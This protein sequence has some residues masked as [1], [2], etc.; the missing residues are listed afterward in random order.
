MWPS[1]AAFTTMKAVVAGIG[2]D[3]V[4]IARFDALL[5]RH[6]GRF[7][8][9]AFAPAEIATFLAKTDRLRDCTDAPTQRATC[10]R[11]EW[12]VDSIHHAAYLPPVC[13]GVSGGAPT[14]QG[15]QL[16]P[17]LPELLV[18]YT[19]LPYGALAYL[20]SRWA[21][22]EALIKAAQE[23]RFLFPEVEVCRCPPAGAPV[24]A[25]SGGQES[26]SGPP[27]FVFHGAAAEYMQAR[28]LHARLSVSHDEEYAVAFVVVQHVGL[29]S[30]APHPASAAPLQ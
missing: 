1:Q 3:V 25:P 15:D 19:N 12:F 9:K 2:V 29:A 13:G 5:A 4:R 23:Y 16:P 11:G 17:A 20:A 30:V 26:G 10:D 14:R 21:A 22:K 7:L 8:L 18:S 24:R 28:G 27:V 6:G